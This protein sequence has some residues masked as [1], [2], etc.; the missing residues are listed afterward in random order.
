MKIDIAIHSSDSNP[1]Y[2]DFWP[3]VSKIWKIKFNILPILLYIDEDH[4]V[5]IDNTYGIVLKYKPIKDIEISLQCLWIRYWITSQ[6]LNEV[7]I[8][9]DIDM[10]PIS[11]KYFIEQIQDVDENKYIHINPFEGYLPSCYHIAKGKMFIEVLKLDDSWE[12]SIKKLYSLKLG[13]SH[14]VENNIFQSWGSDEV[15][16]TKQISDYENKDNLVF[17]K[18]YHDRIDRSDWNY[19]VSDIMNDKYA[20]SHSIRP[21]SKFKH[22]IDILVEIVLNMK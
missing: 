22:N 15:Y 3:I 13:Y 18:R 7:C 12:D 9:S 10:I 19:S 14:I 5:D 20:D 8:I 6:Y 21:Y 17:I 1:F 4:D 2:L 16:A 11:K